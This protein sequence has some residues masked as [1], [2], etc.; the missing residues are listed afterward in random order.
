MA[1]KNTL[2]SFQHSMP[3]KNISSLFETKLA[4]LYDREEAAS[5][6]DLVFCKVF[7]CERASLK[8]LLNENLSPEK[9]S[10]LEQG[11]A[12]LIKGEPVQY[13]LGET[14]FY[15]LT[16]K[17]NPAV[18]I[19]RPETEFLAGLIVKENKQPGLHIMDICTGSGCLAIALE[20]NLRGSVVS[21][22]DISGAALVTAKAN[23]AANESRVTFYQHDMLGNKTLSVNEKYDVIVSNPPYVTES[24]KHDMHINVLNFE[25]HLAL[26]V[27]E[28]DPLVFYK[29]ICKFALRHLKKDGRIYLEINEAHAGE[30]ESLYSSH[31]P[32]VEVKNDLFGR[33]RFLRIS[34]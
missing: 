2:S 9:E 12:R 31:F 18:L 15:G 1:A 7:S 21:A 34:Q 16:I 30:L 24:E 4:A 8:G 27:P 22:L 26:F 11:L 25:P 13:V 20:K 23:A 19:P 33:K 14:S 3:A 5:I 17:V 10:E 28:N 32:V 29:S 6:R